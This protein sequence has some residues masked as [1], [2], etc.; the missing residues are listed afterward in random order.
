MA[1][2]RTKQ[3][4]EQIPD[5]QSSPGAGHNS[6]TDREEQALFFHH[7]K[8]VNNALATKK[9]ADAAYRNACKMAKTEIGDHAVEDIKTST[10]MEAEG[11]EAVVMAEVQRKLRIMRW[12]GRMPGQQGELFKDAVNAAAEAIDP[13]ERGIIAGMNGETSADCPYPIASAEGQ[14]WL[15]G[16]GEGQA[17]MVNLQRRRDAEVFDEAEGKT[18]Q[19]PDDPGPDEGSGDDDPGPGAE[20]EDDDASPDEGEAEQPPTPH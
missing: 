13:F 7:K 3:Q 15:E 6:L 19:E 2:G 4:T 14:K 16:I 9:A 1:R 20:D 12:M 10:A 11:G 5:E 18:T 17:A 8:R